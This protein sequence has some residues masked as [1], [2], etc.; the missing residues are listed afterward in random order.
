MARDAFSLLHFPMLCGVIAYAYALEEM[1]AHPGETLE[2]G[3]RL[4]LTLG[5]GLFVGGLGVAL[6]RATGRVLVPRFLS[7]AGIVVVVLAVPSLTPTAALTV[8]LA[9]LVLTAVLERSVG[10]GREAAAATP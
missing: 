9:G 3:V 8:A 6:W 7:V 2:T 10:E 1:V 5:L 4:A